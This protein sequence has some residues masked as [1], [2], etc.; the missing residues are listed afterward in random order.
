M[1]LKV[2]TAQGEYVD[3]SELQVGDEVLCDDGNYYPVKSIVVFAI[4]PEFIRLTNFVSFYAYPRMQIKTTKGFKYPE[5]DDV[6]QLGKNLCPMVYSA[7]YTDDVKFCYDILI[8][9]NMVSRE[10]IVF[11]FSS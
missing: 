1:N 2:A 3:I 4:H 7:R 11:K 10:G 8:D 5:R 6:L 9:G